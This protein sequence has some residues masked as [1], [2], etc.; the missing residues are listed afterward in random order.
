MS[1]K[2]TLSPDEQIGEV[3]EH[4]PEQPARTLL[5]DGGKGFFKHIPTPPPPPK[6]TV[7]APPGT[8]CPVNDFPCP[9]SHCSYFKVDEGH[10]WCEVDRDKMERERRK[11][12]QP[13]VAAE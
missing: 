2:K 12:G 7:G 9:G 4:V 8:I 11:A 5:D 1:A 13:K 6:Q 3:R 10:K